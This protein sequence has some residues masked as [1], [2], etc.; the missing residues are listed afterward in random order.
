MI[1][2]TFN[3]LDE[4]TQDYLHSLS[5]KDVERRFG[6]QLWEYAVK[7]GLDYDELLEKETMRN[8]YN[9]KYVFAI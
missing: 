9:Y 8:L 1:K 7:H 6:E 2:L 5:K 4:E 3:N